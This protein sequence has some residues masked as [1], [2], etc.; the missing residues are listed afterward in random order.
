AIASPKPTTSVNKY[1]AKLQLTSTSIHL[2][3]GAPLHLH[4]G[5]GPIVLSGTLYPEG[6]ENLGFIR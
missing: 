5:R 2:H 6:L 3:K 4:A 1:A